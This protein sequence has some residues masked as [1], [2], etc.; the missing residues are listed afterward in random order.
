MAIGFIGLDIVIGIQYPVESKWSA[1][2]QK[3][4]NIKEIFGEFY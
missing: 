3:H 1:V 4:L 2:H